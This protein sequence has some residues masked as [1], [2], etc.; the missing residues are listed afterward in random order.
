MCRSASSGRL[1]LNLGSVVRK[2]T[3]TEEASPATTRQRL[4]DSASA[5]FS[6]ASFNGVSIRDIERH[7]GV[8]RGLLSYHFGGKQTLWLNVVDSIYDP[9]LRELSNLASMLRDVPTRER[10]R[11]LR[12]AYVRFNAHHPEFFRL[13]VLEGLERTERTEHL[14]GKLRAGTELYAAMLGSHEPE[15]INDVML[16]HLLIAASA[17]PFVL[18]AFREPV[19]EALGMGD[20]PAATPEFLEPYADLV[21][22]LGLDALSRH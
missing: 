16:R 9:F 15:S 20:D 5:L 13:L 19:L 10:A 18:P 8:E 7:A 22:D 4:L 11:A 14:E 21:A 1:A 12:K 17:A 2:V 3:T 6:A